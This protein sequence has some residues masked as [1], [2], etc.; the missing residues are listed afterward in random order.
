MWGVHIFRES[1]DR[2]TRGG[3]QANWTL[4][5]LK[6]ILPHYEFPYPLIHWHLLTEQRKHL[7]V[8]LICQRSELIILCTLTSW[9]LVGADMGEIYSPIVQHKHKHKEKLFFQ[10]VPKIPKYNLCWQVFKSV[11]IP[12]YNSGVGGSPKVWRP[13]SHW[14]IHMVSRGSIPHDILPARNLETFCGV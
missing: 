11:Y 7:T 6:V 13:F 3:V 5:K 10:N 12:Y 8:Y 9:N 14:S 2:K 1:K 4:W